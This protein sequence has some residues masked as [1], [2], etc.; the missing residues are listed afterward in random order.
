MRQG[1][2]LPIAMRIQHLAELAVRT[3][4]RAGA[5]AVAAELWRRSGGHLDP[6][7]VAAFL[8]EEEQ[9]LAELDGLDLLAAVISAEPGP[10]VLTPPDEL[11]GLCLTLAILADL[12]GRYLLGHSAHVAALA[13][14][15]AAISGLAEPDRAGL[16]AA[17]LLHDLGRAAVPSSLWDRPG[18]LSV[19]EREQVRLHAYWT[20]RI[21]RRCPALSYLAPVAAGHHERCDGSGYHRGIRSAELSPAAR[22]LGC[23]DVYA[24]ATEDRPH[25]RAL[26]RDAAAGLLAT[27]AAAG[28]LDRD[29]SDALIE[30]AGHPRPRA[31]RPSGLTEREV[32]VLRLAAR[33]MSNRQIAAELGVA[34]RTVGHHLAHIFDKTGRRTR[35]GAAVFALEHSL[36]MK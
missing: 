31:D 15:A 4:A 26:S 20:D 27:E 1:E 24:S 33:G 34:E 36:L 2:Q 32:E 10:P 25:R 9:L 6:D 19:G 23:A 29:A 18:P 13:D 3:R 12:K 30:A 22:L 5:P 17:G 14:G 21:L 7:L 11:D 16:R 28:R 8:G 35:A